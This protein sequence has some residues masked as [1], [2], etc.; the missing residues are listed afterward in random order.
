LTKKESIELENNLIKFHDNG[1][2]FNVMKTAGIVKKISYKEFND[3]FYYDETSPSFL[4]HRV[5]KKRIKAGTIAG[6][7]DAKGYWVVKFK[8][9]SYLVHRVII[10]LTTLEDIA[11]GMVVDH[12]DGNP[13]NNNI[14]NLRVV[15]QKDNCRNFSSNTGKIKRLTWEENGY[16][17]RWRVYYT[18][19][20]HGRHT[21]SFNPSVLYPKLPL[22]ESKELARIAAMEYLEFTEDLYYS[23]PYSSNL[24]Y[25]AASPKMGL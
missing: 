3:N 20:S 11:E 13:S 14:N 4:R 22:E 7:L 10:V 18:D 24:C 25:N 19:N 17:C 15:S 9:V 2:L 12:L 6:M 1:Q 21:K 16:R 5:D 8:S 23:I